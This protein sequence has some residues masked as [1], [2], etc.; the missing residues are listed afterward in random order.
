M[1]TAVRLIIPRLTD[2]DF[3]GGTEHMNEKPALGLMGGHS[4]GAGQCNRQRRSRWSQA[5]RGG[6]EKP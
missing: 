5:L 4:L 6:F 3:L 1:S 2:E